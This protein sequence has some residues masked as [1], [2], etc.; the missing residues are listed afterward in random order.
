MTSV[1]I[2]KNLFLFHTQCFGPPFQRGEGDC[3]KLTE[4]LNLS[5][6]LSNI[7]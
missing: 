6:L 7:A 3:Y 1:T 5:W 4:Q 2:R